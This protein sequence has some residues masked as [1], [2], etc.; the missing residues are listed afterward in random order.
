MAWVSRRDRD[1][2][3]GRDSYDVEDDEAWSSILA[4]NLGRE[5]SRRNICRSRTSVPTRQI[6]RKYRSQAKRRLSLAPT[7]GGSIGP[8][9]DL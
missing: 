7:G 6:Y 1:L 8:E 4:L 3:Y 5:L 2:R 9:R